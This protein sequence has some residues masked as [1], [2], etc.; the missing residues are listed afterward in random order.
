MRPAQ[1]LEAERSLL[2]AMLIEPSRVAEIACQ[3]VP[4]DFFDPRHQLVFRAITACAAKL[5]GID[6]VTVGSELAAMRSLDAVGGRAY[7]VE[8]TNTVTSAAHARHHATIVRDASRLRSWAR[9]ATDALETLRDMPPGTDASLEAQADLATRAVTIGAEAQPEPEHIAQIADRVEAVV[10]AEYDGRQVGLP[11]GLVDVDRQI[12]GLRGGDLIVVAA[13][14]GMGK[15]AFATTVLMNAIGKATDGHG[16]FCSMEMGRDAIVER[17]ICARAGVSLHRTRKY[18]ATAAD[19]EALRSAAFDIRSLPVTIFDM[20]AQSPMAIRGMA[21]RVMHKQRALS[22]IVVDYLQLIRVRGV[23]R[24]EEVSEASRTLKQI[25][26]E[27][28]VPVLA[29]AQLS[30]N[31]E[32]RP[33]KVPQLSDLRESGS[34]EQDADLVL[35]LYRESYYDDNAADKTATDVIL[36]KSRNGPVGKVTVNFEAELMRFTDR[37][38][39]E[40]WTP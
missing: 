1:N 27:F 28:N 21:Q 23:S 20:P 14:P 35:L 10:T 33:S 16:L 22:L 32:N 30:R 19:R 37:A 6:F 7:L 39:V 26:R 12:C 9:L 2:G 8:I 18:G 13:R 17:M 11:T 25:A 3:L 34:I 24:I 36:A 31:V 40:N 38:K 29:L 15:T 4:E 5:I